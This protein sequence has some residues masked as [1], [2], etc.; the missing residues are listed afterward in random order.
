M[1]ALPALATE[2]STYGLTEDELVFWERA[3]LAMAPSAIKC[4]D[5]T[6]ANERVTSGAKRMELCALWAD[7]AV[8]Q[9]S[10]RLTP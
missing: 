3:F 8:K 4:Q 2:K 5:W 6:I 7:H 9:R 10:K 1:A